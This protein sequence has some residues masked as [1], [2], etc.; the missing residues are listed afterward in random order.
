MISW[1]VYFKYIAEIG[2][3]NGTG[4]EFYQQSHGTIQDTEKP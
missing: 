4:L 3:N 2:A 1:L